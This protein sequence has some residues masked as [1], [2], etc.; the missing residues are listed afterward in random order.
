MG[1][2][3]GNKVSTDRETY[4][5]TT[6]GLGMDDRRTGSDERDGAVAAGSADGFVSIR[7]ALAGLGFIWL[8]AMAGIGAL[9]A[10]VYGATTSSGYLLVAALAA[11]IAVA[12][13]IASLRTFGYR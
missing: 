7:R 4:R 2:P 12:A 10:A 6:P 5:R 13:G 3:V 8:S 11:L 9:A 1:A